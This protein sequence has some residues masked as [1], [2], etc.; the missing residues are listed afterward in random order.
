MDVGIATSG[1]FEVLA[2]ELGAAEA[3]RD[4]KFLSRPEKF[5]VASGVRR[6]QFCW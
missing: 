5:F 4:K 1:G 3:E 6:A 2:T